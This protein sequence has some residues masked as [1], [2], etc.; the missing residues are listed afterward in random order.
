MKRRASIDLLLVDHA[1]HI[2]K[3]SHVY[4]SVDL[5]HFPFA[6]VLVRGAEHCSL[7]A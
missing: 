7:L 3:G 2:R 6:L 5:Q 4:M 1:S